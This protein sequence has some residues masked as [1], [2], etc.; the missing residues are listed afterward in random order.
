[1]IKVIRPAT[2]STITAVRPSIAGRKPGCLPS[3]T[4]RILLF[5]GEVLKTCGFP[6]RGT[7]RNIFEGRQP[8]L[9]PVIDGRTVDIVYMAAVPGPS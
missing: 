3:K 7:Y 1:M 4:F 5:P 6:F 2:L 8:C 9:L